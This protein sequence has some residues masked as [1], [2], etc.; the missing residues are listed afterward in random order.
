MGYINQKEVF[1]N[2]ITFDHSWSY[3]LNLGYSIKDDLGVFA[4]IFGEGKMND[5]GETPLNIDGGIWYRINPKLQ[6]DAS[7]GYGFEVESHY[8][9]MGFSWLLIN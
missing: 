3:T 1:Q 9:N 7:A 5:N 4:E 6:V 2:D 8:L